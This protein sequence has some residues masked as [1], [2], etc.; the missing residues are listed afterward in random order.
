MEL[1]NSKCG[2]VEN[3]AL[4][5]NDNGE[6]FSFGLN[7][8]G[9]LGH[10]EE[11]EYILIPKKINI[12]SN[13]KM[14]DCGIK[15]VC[16]V[17]YIGDV[18]TF[19]DNTL[20]QLGIDTSRE[21]RATHIPQKMQNIPPIN[22]ILCDYYYNLCLTFDGNLYINGTLLLNNSLSHSREGYIIFGLPMIFNN[23]GEIDFITC[24][25]NSIVFKTKSNKFYVIGCNQFGKLGASQDIISI[26][27][28]SERPNWP[29]NIIDIKCF[30]N[31]TLLLTS[32]GLAHVIG[33]MYYN[34]FWSIGYEMNCI[35]PYTIKGLPF[36]KQIL[37]GGTYFI[38][39][40]EYNKKWVYGMHYN[41]NIGICK[42]NVLIKPTVIPILSNNV[43]DMQ[44]SYNHIVFKKDDD[45]IIFLGYMNDINCS[46]ISLRENCEMLKYKSIHII[47]NDKEDMWSSSIYKSRQKSA[48]K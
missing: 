17:N 34:L 40:D 36:I 3:G 11:E 13:I 25:S 42:K 22:F 7:D 38:L 48:R 1:I 39:V 14:I 24:G 46:R 31:R 2:L 6:V 23:S 41:D 35:N 47:D 32:D 18:F 21:L 44:C 8:Y 20:S 10:D 29:D 28:F 5:I 45:T 30:H 12:L 26:Y 16:C 37:G 43:V 33:K 9:Y 4:F 27:S 15:H 19:G